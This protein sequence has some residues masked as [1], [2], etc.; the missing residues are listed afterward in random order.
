M[1]L[2]GVPAAEGVVDRLAFESEER[3]SHFDW[4]VKSNC[5][6][7]GRRA[8]NE[9]KSEE[10]AEERAEIPAAMPAGSIR[11]DVAG[12]SDFAVLHE[13]PLCCGVYIP[14]QEFANHIP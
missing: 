12:R 8:G 1:G 6:P 7:L 5:E 2:K 10:S 3:L 11:E 9:S 13:M 14:L 4:V